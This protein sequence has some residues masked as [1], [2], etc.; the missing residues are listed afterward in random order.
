MAGALEYKPYCS[1]I[2]SLVCAGKFDEAAKT[3]QSLN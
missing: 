1:D 3:A 2:E